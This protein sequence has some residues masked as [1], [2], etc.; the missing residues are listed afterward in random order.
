MKHLQKNNSYVNI[1]LKVLWTILS[2]FSKGFNFLNLIHLS[3][4][5]QW[6]TFFPYQNLCKASPNYK[7]K[8][9]RNLD[10]ISDQSLKLTVI[11]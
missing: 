8:V 10:Y 6:P 7:I 9:A 4:I 5:L 11:I 1:F 3:D 2:L